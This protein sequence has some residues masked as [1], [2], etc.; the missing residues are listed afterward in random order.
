MD[1][2]R[3]IELLKQVHRALNCLPTCGRQNL[4]LTLISI[5]HVETVIADLQAV[6]ET[7]EKDHE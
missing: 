4:E 6:D 5:S 1:K 2:A 7:P 3:D